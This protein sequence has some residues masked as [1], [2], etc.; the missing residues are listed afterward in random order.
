MTRAGT[1]AVAIAAAAI[2][3]PAHGA[4][5]QGAAAAPSAPVAITAARLIVG[6]GSVIEHPVVI[7]TGDRI[8]A[9]GPAGKVA[10]PAG[11]R[12]IDLG[13]RTLLPGLI[14]CHTH[15]TSIDNDGGD[16]AVLKENGAFEAIY[17]VINAKKT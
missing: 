3:V 5:A 15:I 11:A 14:D 8:T 16:M 6:D 2:G 12:T 9:V 17:G 13:T 1:L 4:R 7:V 10:I